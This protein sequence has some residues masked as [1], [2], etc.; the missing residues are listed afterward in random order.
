MEG[1]PWCKCKQEGG[2]STLTSGTCICTHPTHAAW[3]RQGEA[4]LWYKKKKKR[5]EEEEREA[6]EEEEEEEEEERKREKKGKNRGR[7][8]KRGEGGGRRARRKRGRR[9]KEGEEEY[10][11]RN[12]TNTQ[13]KYQH[14]GSNWRPSACEADVITNYTMSAEWIPA[15]WK[16]CFRS[17][18]QH[19]RAETRRG[20]QKRW[21]HT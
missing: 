6:E 1:G 11:E 7:G 13:K 18:G 8:D 4:A 2:P 14:P 19:L 21:S 15:A 5:E 17:L 9:R 12:T 10:E 16:I 20:A 3:D